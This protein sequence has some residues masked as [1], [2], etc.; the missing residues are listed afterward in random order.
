LLID[1]SQKVARPKKEI[2]KRKKLTAHCTI[3]EALTI[4]A[5]AEMCRLSV[6]EY[7]LKVGLEKNVEAKLSKVEIEIYRKLVGMANNV[8]QIA[9][10]GNQTGIIDE[11]DLIDLM[12]IRTLVL[13]LV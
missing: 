7:L 10:R 13:K 6:S 3:G 8:N 4:K 11:E 2:K 1:D 12:K 5:K 9:K